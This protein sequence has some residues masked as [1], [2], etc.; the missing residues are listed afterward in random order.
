MKSI[1]MIR[2][3]CNLRIFISYTRNMNRAKTIAFQENVY[4]SHDNVEQKAIATKVLST[5]ILANLFCA[6]ALYI[7][8]LVF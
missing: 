8:Y 4:A 3:Y 1:N 5:L 2:Y 7:I 6:V